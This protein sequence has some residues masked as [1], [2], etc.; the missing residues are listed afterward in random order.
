MSSAAGATGGRSVDYSVSGSLSMVATDSAV[1]NVSV[2]ATPSVLLANT[3]SGSQR[4]AKSSARK[5][6]VG[7]EGSSSTS[8]AGSS[9]SG[10]LKRG[11]RT[12]AHTFSAT[13]P[14]A[15]TS[16]SLQQYVLSAA[17]KQSGLSGHSLE[18]SLASAN[19]SSGRAPSDQGEDSS[20]GSGPGA[21]G[22]TYS[23]DFPDSTKDT[24]VVSPPDS[25]NNALFVFEPHV[26]EG[27][28]D[29]ADYQFLRPT[30]HVG[31]GKSSGGDQQ[32][33]DL[34]RRINRR[35]NA[36]RQAEV[37]GKS[38]KGDHPQNPFA[39]PASSADKLNKLSNFGPSF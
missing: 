24:A 15:G 31:G 1:T 34:Y 20:S 2:N 12:P 4:G 19:L 6:A 17:S 37:P 22:G 13:S 5:S 30:L 11:L 16:T 39:K 36:Y 3:S 27:F 10:S 25:A 7:S 29:L 35:L 28:P 8:A 21:E 14:S 33:E 26:S 38:L 23:T 18:S 32:K 9:G